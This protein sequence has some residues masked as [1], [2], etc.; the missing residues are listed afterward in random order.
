LKKNEIKK[1]NQFI[2]LN[3]KI[4]NLILKIKKKKIENNFQKLEKQIQNKKKIS[5]FRT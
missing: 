1:K 5:F 2:F 3:I 4:W